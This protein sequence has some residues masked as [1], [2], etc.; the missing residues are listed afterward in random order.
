M[1]RILI[2]VD[3]T[4]GTKNAFSM[5]GHVC[6]CIRPEAVMLV[7]VEKLEGRSL[8]D[9]VLLSVSE[10]KT[11]KEALEG[12][13]YQDALDKRAQKILD[14]YKKALEERGVSGVETIVRKGHPAEEILATAREKKADMII[15]GAR[16]KRTTHLFMGSVSREVAN[17]AD[18]PVLLVKGSPSA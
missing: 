9:D 17:G 2:A 4:K 11:L 15:I 5:C 10:M 14:Y 7:Y 13:E 16:G 8:M 18:V 1:K 6:S 12:T 3:D